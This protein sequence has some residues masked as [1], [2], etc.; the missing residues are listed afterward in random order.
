MRV[1]VDEARRDQLAGRVNLPLR[2][3]PVDVADGGDYP[4]LHGDV[5]DVR[6]TSQPVDDGPVA[7]D[8]VVGHLNNLRPC[9][10]LMPG[11][12]GDR[13]FR[14]YLQRLRQVAAVLRHRV[15]CAGLFTATRF[16]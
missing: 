3:G 8:E 13:S 6:L 11:S 7:D 12:F 9:R 2:P 15:G 4:V 10:S 16:R 1:Q 5:T 14:D